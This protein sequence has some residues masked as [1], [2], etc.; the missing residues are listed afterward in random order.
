MASCHFVGL[1]QCHYTKRH[2]LLREFL[3]TYEVLENNLDLYFTM[4]RALFPHILALNPCNQVEVGALVI[5]VC[6]GGIDPMQFASILVFVFPYL[7][8]M[9]AVKYYKSGAREQSVNSDGKS[10]NIWHN[11]REIRGRLIFSGRTHSF[12]LYEAMPF[13]QFSIHVKSTK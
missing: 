11:Q 3:P 4:Y 12:H 8:E 5:L 2:F 9:L 13:P 7:I 6:I 10:P 1:G